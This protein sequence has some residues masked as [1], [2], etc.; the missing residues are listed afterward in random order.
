MNR[1][2][3]MILA[4][5]ALTMSA[6]AAGPEYRRPDMQLPTV[7]HNGQEIAANPNASPDAAWW[8][9]F[10]DPELSQIIARTLAQNLD[11]AAAAQRAE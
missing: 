9:G 5:I 1:V 10:H 6:C 3:A 2:T 4:F 11:V 7:F 8:D